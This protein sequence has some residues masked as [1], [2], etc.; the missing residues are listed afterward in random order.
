MEISSSTAFN[1]LL[2]HQIWQHYWGRT[3]RHR[4]Y[5][6]YRMKL[7]CR[8]NIGTL[9]RGIRY[10]NDQ[11]RLQFGTTCNRYVYITK[12][13]VNETVG[14]SCVN[15]SII[16]KI[17]SF[18]KM[19]HWKYLPLRSTYCD[20]CWNW[21][22]LDLKQFRICYTRFMIVCAHKCITRARVVCND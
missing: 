21:N 7:T 15:S 12:L 16:K 9:F 6:R 22:W 8:V 10:V 18:R 20:T 3:F 4:H 11:D 1:S 19:K 2:Q 14:I 5:Q 17:H 13:C